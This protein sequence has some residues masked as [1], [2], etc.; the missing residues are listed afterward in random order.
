LDGLRSVGT[1]ESPQ[2]LPS[3]GG[4]VRFPPPERQGFTHK[5]W[6]KVKA[7]LKLTGK[8][9]LYSFKHISFSNT[10]KGRVAPEENALIAGQTNIRITE[11]YR[12]VQKPEVEHAFR[13]LEEAFEPIEALPL[14][15]GKIEQNEVRSQA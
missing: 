14:R 4:K 8:A 5:V 2:S 11:R 10:R 1:A 3:A 13:V 12:R 9:T 15:G 6:P 7:A